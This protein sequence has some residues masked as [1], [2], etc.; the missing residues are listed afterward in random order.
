VNIPLNG[1]RVSDC[2]PLPESPPR[3]NES[4]ASLR[5]TKN[6]FRVDSHNV[7]GLRDETK[8][9]YIPRM[10]KNKEIDAYLIGP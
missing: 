5:I 1:I 3:A 8:L 7:N 2:P 6:N 10:M 9:E 4:S